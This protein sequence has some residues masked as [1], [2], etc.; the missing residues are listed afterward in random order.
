VSIGVRVLVRVWG[1]QDYIRVCV[2]QESEQVKGFDGAKEED[3]ELPEA[4]E[5]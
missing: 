2:D 3:K 1:T 5:G 4:V